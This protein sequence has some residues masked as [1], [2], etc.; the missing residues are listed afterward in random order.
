MRACSSRALP[1]ASGVA[2]AAVCVL[3]GACK[4]GTDGTG[5]LVGV[6]AVRGVLVENS[7]GTTALPTPSPLEYNVEIREDHGV[8]YWMPAKSSQNAG[9]LTTRGE[10]SF[11]ATQS[12]VLSMTQGGQQLQPTDFQTLQPDF[13]LQ[14]KTCAVT[15]MRRISGSLQRRNAADG[16]FVTEIG[17]VDAGADDDLVGTDIV[18]IA[19]SAGSDCNASLSALGGTYL[20]LPCGARYLLTGTL[21]AA[22]NLNGT[23]TQK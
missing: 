22:A 21:A 4:Q 17:S 23:G 2:C 3:L 5:T 1:H 6:Y 15:S 16:G 20:A 12:A 8:G 9:S 13:D 19:P 7:C 11:S 18:E 14:K 10:F